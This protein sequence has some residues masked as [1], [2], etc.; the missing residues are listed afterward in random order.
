MK[1]F[2]KRIVIINA[3]FAT[4]WVIFGAHCVI[5]RSWLFLPI[6]LAMIAFNAY[7]AIPSLQALVNGEDE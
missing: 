6:A 2:D 3:I 4:G 7:S 5:Q 1:K